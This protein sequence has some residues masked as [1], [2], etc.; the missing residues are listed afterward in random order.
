[1]RL[2]SIHPSYLDRQ[3]LLAL[4]REGLL[5]KKVLEAKTK[6][7]RHH[8]QLARF[9][10]HPHP[11]PAINR[12]LWAVYRESLNWGYA[13]SREKIGSSVPKVKTI[14]VPRGQIAYEFKH[15]LGKLRTRDPERYKH[16][17]HLAKPRCHPSFT[18][19]PGEIEPWEKLKS[20]SSGKIHDLWSVQRRKKVLKKRKGT[21]V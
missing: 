15:L 6:G 4:W 13:F 9:Y 5:A 19:I 21:G 11:L 8:P 7:Y 17:R 10:T 3:G 16:Y 12:Y 14:T 20:N 2:W 18:V 1:M